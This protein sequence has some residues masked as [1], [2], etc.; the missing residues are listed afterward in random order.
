MSTMMVDVILPGVVG[1]K[2]VELRGVHELDTGTALLLIE[3]G[4]ARPA[5]ASAEIA[6]NNGVVMS[7]QDNTINVLNKELEKMR[8]TND[9]LE[10]ALVEAKKVV[11]EQQ[12]RI[13]A[14]EAQPIASPA[15]PVDAVAEEPKKS[16]RKNSK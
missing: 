1:D 13:D 4:K 10:T 8:K 16:A 5:S 3:H 2:G 15:E 6:Q 7:A 11:R 9:A 12:E 14:L